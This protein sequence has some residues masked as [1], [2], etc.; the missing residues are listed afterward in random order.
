LYEKMWVPIERMAS[1]EKNKT[2]GM[3]LLSWNL[4][5]ENSECFC[6][7]LAGLL[8]ILWGLL[9]F[10]YFLLFGWGVT[11]HTKGKR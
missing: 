9:Y 5:A 6:P 1:D 3:I 7:E 10:T 4:Q 2:A 11:T 8:T